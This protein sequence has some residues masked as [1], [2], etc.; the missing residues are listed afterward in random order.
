MIGRL[1]DTF[2]TLLAGRANSGAA[3][4]LGF[5]GLVAEIKGLAAGKTTLLRLRHPDL[6]FPFVIRVPS[7]DVRTY[8]Q[9]FVEREFDFDVGKPPETIVDA[10]ANIGLTSIYLAG[11]FPRA[12]I[13]AIEPEESNLAILRRNIAPYDNIVSLAGALWHRDS[14]I[15]LVDPGLGKWGFMT[16]SSDGPGDVPGEVIQEVRGMT[17][18]TIMEEQGLDRI[19]ILK[20]DIEGAERE[21]FQNP[22][23]WIG[24]VGALI[25]ELHERMKPGCNRSFYLGTGG[26]DN[27]WIQ[28]ENL[29]LSRNSGCLRRSGS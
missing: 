21:V 16:R 6:A 22:S 2:I 1:T 9:V 18:G 27:E 7:S 23:G 24:K 29:Y 17:V 8:E 11:R 12:K 15:S 5:R 3:R 26:F 13:I 14:M 25:V 10:G 4:H 20:V 19:D 28:G